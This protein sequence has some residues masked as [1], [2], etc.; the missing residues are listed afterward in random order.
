MGRAAR[1]SELKAGPYCNGVLVQTRKDY[2]DAI[3]N[4]GI[5]T[6]DLD[7]GAEYGWVRRAPNKKLSD[8]K[9]MVGQKYDSVLHETALAMPEDYY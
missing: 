9:V 7:L 2:S 3:R 4:K 5:S 1:A 8:V 6:E